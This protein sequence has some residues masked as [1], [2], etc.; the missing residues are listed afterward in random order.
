MN[1]DDIFYGR[2]DEEVLIHEDINEAIYEQLD[3]MPQPFPKTITIFEWK[4]MELPLVIREDGRDLLDHI[5]EGLNDDYGDQNDG[6]S[7]FEF[8]EDE[9]ELAVEFLEKLYEMYVPWTCELSGKKEV[10][11]IKSWVKEHKPHWLD[12]ADIEFEEDKDD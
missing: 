1:K 12:A 9:E 11:N 2:E 4:R 5:E 8:S 6:D 10:V 7:S 3:E